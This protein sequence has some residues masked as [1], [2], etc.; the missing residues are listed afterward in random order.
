MPILIRPAKTSEDLDEILKLRFEGLVHEGAELSPEL[1]A[2][3]KS[4]DHLDIFPDTFNFFALVKGRVGAAIRAVNYNLSDPTMNFIFD[5]REA[6]LGLQKKTALLDYLALSPDLSFP[7]ECTV[8]LVKASLLQL[9]NLGYSAVFMS[10]PKY[11][12]EAI[13]QMGFIPVAE[14]SMNSWVDDFVTP[15]VL[16]LDKY[17]TQAFSAV[18]D[19]EF[20]KF[21]ELF[22][23]TIFEP[24]EL[25]A[26]QGEK[27]QTA[28]LIENGS[29]EVVLSKE[30]SLSSLA[31][32]KK[33]QLIGELAMITRESRTASLVA[34]EMTTCYSVD[35]ND[36]LK[37]LQKD[38]YRSLDLFKICSKRL[39]AVNKRLAST[40]TTS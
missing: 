18:L 40:R 16:D 15:C 38:P 30:D 28:Y 34:K 36:F 14:E 33:G 1:R 26:V 39:E 5:Y 11:F 2:I 24:G 35:R 13:S 20:L 21:R 17:V 22:T 29:V 10:V 3:G 37:L 25:L 31:E 12:L 32:L 27:G 4:V 19:R 23:L 6:F 7:R 9:S 8:G